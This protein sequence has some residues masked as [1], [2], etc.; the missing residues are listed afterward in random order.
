MIP[1][2]ESLKERLLPDRTLDLEQRFFQGLCLLAA[3]VSI[4]VVIPLDL[5]Q[6]LGPWVDAVSLCFGVVSLAIYWEARHGRYLRK[7]MLFSYV[8]CLDL[9]WFPNGGSQGSIGLHFFEVGLGLVLF[10]RGRFR[11]AGLALLVANITALLLAERAWPDLAHPFRWPSGRLLDLTAGY[12]ISLLVCS[13]MLWYV[14]GGLE[15]EQAR[16]RQALDETRRAQAELAESRSRLFQA[17]KMESL[18]SLAGGIAHDMNNVLGA[19]LGLASV[20]E[21]RALPGTD[22]ARDMGTIRLAC[23]RGGSMVKGLLGFARKGV[24]EERDVDLNA[25]AREQVALL[26]RTTLRRVILET[27]LADGLRQVRGDPAALGLALMN[28]CLNAVDAMPGGG[29]LLIRTFNGPEGTVILEVTDTGTGMPPDVVARAMDPFFTTKPQGQGTGL[30]LSIAF[31]TLAAHKGSL[32][33]QSRPGRGTQVRLRLPG[34]EA[35]LPGPRATGALGPSRRSLKVLV[36]DDDELVRESLEA[37]LEALG[38]ACAFAEGGEAA[39]ARL[40]AGLRP[41]VVLLDMNMPGMDGGATLPRLR[42]LE[43]DVPVLL[44]TGR[45]DQTA[46]DLVA[47]HAGVSLLGKPFGI[48]DLQAHLDARTAG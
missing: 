30:G 2:L 1:R 18:G 27:D 10:F 44:V 47:S 15:R 5:F 39:L 21:H 17:Q 25:L 41:D 42:L 43:P 26:E 40:E 32:D 23:E 13:L 3:L 28:I 4:F 8:V 29:S 45:V 19:I 22:Q 14:L 34:L 33:I 46:L 7:A 9:L 12:A 6:D 11:Y 36:V 31:A 37:L 16:L 38:H 48:R 24:S 20:H 35:A